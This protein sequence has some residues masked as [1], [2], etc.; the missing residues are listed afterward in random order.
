MGDCGYEEVEVSGEK[1][2]WDFDWE[3]DIWV[4]ARGVPVRDMEAA[5][6]LKGV[7]LTPAGV[8]VVAVSAD[9]AGVRGGR[10]ARGYW[11]PIMLSVMLNRNM[12]VAPISAILNHRVFQL[13]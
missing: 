12:A 3:L 2:W 8:E 4:E 6:P 5:S 13:F 11:M 10:G 9:L 7:W 1:G